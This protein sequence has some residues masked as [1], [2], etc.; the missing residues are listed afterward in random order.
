[1]TRSRRD[2]CWFVPEHAARSGTRVMRGHGVH[3]VVVM[4]EHGGT[5]GMITVEDLFE[6]VVG[7]IDEGEDALPAFTDEPDGGVVVAGTVR[8]DE[9]GEHLDRDDLDHEEADTV[10]GLVLLLLGRPARPNDR[11]EYNGLA[12]LVQAVANRGVRRCRVERLPPAAAGAERRGVSR[13][14]ATT[15]LA[16]DVIPWAERPDQAR[17]KAN[18]AAGGGATRH[19]AARPGRRTTDQPAGDPGRPRPYAAGHD[20]LVRAPEV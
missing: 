17:S 9:L 5:A 6:E 2:P 19:L 10:S 4:D 18:G 12:F 3:V 15:W 14:A 16:G 20:P 1:M 8:L 11:V 13:P 7:E